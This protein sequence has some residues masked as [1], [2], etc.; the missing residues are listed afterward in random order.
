MM[1]VK[2]DEVYI[3]H[4]TGDLPLGPGVVEVEERLGK[5]LVDNFPWARQVAEPRPKR[6]PKEG[7][8][9]ERA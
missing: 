3:G 5:Y 1:K 9:D 8:R 2:L 6:K 4:M 7:R